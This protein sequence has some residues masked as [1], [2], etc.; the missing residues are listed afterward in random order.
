MSRR[1]SQSERV[2]RWSSVV[3]EPVYSESRVGCV[4]LAPSSI[5]LHGDSVKIAKEYGYVVLD[6]DGPDTVTAP[7]IATKQTG[8]PAGSRTS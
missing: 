2:S 8:V 5:A 7:L 4:A 6:P 3:A 1:G